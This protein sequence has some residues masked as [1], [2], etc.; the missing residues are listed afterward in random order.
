MHKLTKLK[1][2][3]TLVVSFLIVIILF[4]FACLIISTK[5]IEFSNNTEDSYYSYIYPQ[6]DLFKISSD[7]DTL[8]KYVSELVS[9]TYIDNKYDSSYIL[10]DIENLSW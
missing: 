8:T 3:E 1:I 6:E 2:R 4:F 7:F 5:M 10:N 9:M